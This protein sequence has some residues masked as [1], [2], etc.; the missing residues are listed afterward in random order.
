M[1]M[2][3]VTI[4]VPDQYL[5]C[6]ETLVNMG[7]FPSRSEVVREALKVFLTNEA[8]LNKG[9]DHQNFEVMKRQQMNTMLH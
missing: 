6:I 1:P 5:D 8:E 2:K 4:N 9:L 7:F 3:I